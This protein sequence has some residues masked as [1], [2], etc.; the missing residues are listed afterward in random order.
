M[1]DALIR[2]EDLHGSLTDPTL[3]SMNLLNEISQRYP[4][5]V[6]FAAGR[7]HEG[8]WAVEDL[9]RY[10]RIFCEHLAGDRGMTEADI[11]RLLFQYGRTNGVIGDLVADNLAKDEG[12]IVDPQ[13]VVVTVGCQEAMLL[14]VRALVAGPRDAVLAVEPTYVG[15]AG[16]ARLLDIPV[17]PVPAGEDGIDHEGLERALA[18]AR[19]KGINP[20]ALYVIP[21]FSNPLGVSVSL[22]GRRRLLDWATRED[23]LLLEDNPYGLFA[24]GTERLPTLKAL[25]TDRRV[26]YLGSY[27][28]TAL[29]GVRIGFAVADQVVADAAGN[30]LGLL[31]DQLGKIKSMVSVNTPPV[32]QAVL[33]GRLLEAGGSLV[34]AN[35][36]TRSVYRENLTRLLA[37]LAARFPA[38]GPGP[39]VTWN[40]PSGGFF[41]VVGVEFETTMA[42]LEHSANAHGVLWTP[43][44]QFYSDLRPTRQLRLSFSAL[45]P[46]DIEIGLDRLEAFI[47][48]QTPPH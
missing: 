8:G 21:D 35:T 20:R 36:A 44:G 23:I 6:S 33:G 24:A 42:L 32:A 22:A 47:R 5:A 10:L 9:H 43:M 25:D 11:T 34:T 38:A 29:P 15:L 18:E 45:G 46:A 14:A 12:I 40:V 4:H 48:E 27:A 19:A 37:G 2:I 13:A 3:D 28:K 16:A 7:P 39:K 30:R 17:L 41:V 1:S 26:V 31:A